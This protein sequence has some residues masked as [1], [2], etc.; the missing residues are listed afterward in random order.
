MLN[1]F[2]HL[3]T[4]NK[5]LMAKKKP[6]KKRYVYLEDAIKEEFLLRCKQYSQIDNYLYGIEHEGKKHPITAYRHKKLGVKGGISDY[7]F[8]YNNGKHPCLWLEFKAAKNT[9]SPKQKV[10]K[11]I[12]ESQG[13]AYI[14]AWSA[15]EGINAILNYLEEKDGK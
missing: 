8:L 2:L 6:I 4:V 15:E 10:F 14:T 9:L 13:H 7:L 11:E 5:S 1:R 3:K 12:A